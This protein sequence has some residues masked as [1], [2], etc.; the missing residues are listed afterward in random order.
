MLLFDGFCKPTTKSPFTFVLF[1]DD[2]CLIFTIQ[3]FVGGMTKIDER[4]WI[5]TYCFIHSSLPN[6]SDTS[7]GIK[8]TYFPYIH[9]PHTQI[10][11]NPSLSPFEL[12]PQ[13]QT[14]CGKPEPLYTTQ[15]SDLF[16]I[17]QDGFKMHTG[18]PNLQSVKNEYISGRIILDSTTKHY[19]FAALNVSN[20]FATIDYDAHI[21]TKKGL[22]GYSG[23]LKLKTA[24]KHAKIAARHGS[25]RKILNNFS[26]ELSSVDSYTTEPSNQHKKKRVKN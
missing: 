23:T 21:N 18:Q 4:Y 20:N 7:S 14:F 10:P 25:H 8:G 17:Y 12:F 3:D 16:V 13:T 2:F 24:R 6:K 26:S 9:A 22:V 5:E 11:H 15:Y 1:S 19:V